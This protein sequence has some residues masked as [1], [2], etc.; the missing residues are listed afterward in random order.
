LATPAPAN[1]KMDAE[2]STP[3]ISAIVH[4][5]SLNK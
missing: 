1:G 5:L 3:N 2:F 4:L